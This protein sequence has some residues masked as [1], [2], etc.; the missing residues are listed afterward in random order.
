MMSKKIQ[1]DDSETAKT[2]NDGGYPHPTEECQQQ[3]LCDNEVG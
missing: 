1:F 2:Q 3:V